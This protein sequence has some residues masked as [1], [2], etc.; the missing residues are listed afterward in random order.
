MGSRYL[1]I[2]LMVWLE[3]R[4]T[5]GDYRR[6]EQQDFVPWTDGAAPAAMPGG[7]QPH[8]PALDKPGS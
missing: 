4:L 7:T 6:T 1:H 5:M 3:K 2:V 8:A